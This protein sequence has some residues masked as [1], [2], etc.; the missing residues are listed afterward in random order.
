M[1]ALVVGVSAD[2]KEVQRRFVERFLLT[3]PLI[4]DH[5][6]EIIDAYDAR[7]VLGVVAKR[8][9][10]LI[11]PEGKIAHI[12]PHVKVEGHADDVIET[13][14]ALQKETAQV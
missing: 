3:F 6:K 10:F 11:D 2:S 7:Q 9:T 1:N 14:K 5:N 4:S 8:T 13:M 12:W